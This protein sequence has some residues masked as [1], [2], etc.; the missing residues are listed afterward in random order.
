MDQIKNWLEEMRSAYLYQ[1][2]ADNEQ[3]LLQ[4]KMFKELQNAALKQAS[5]WEKSIKENHLTLPKFKPDLRIK[6][7]S[8]LVKIIGVR[9]LR[10]ILSAMKI[11]GMSALSASSH[12]EHQHLTTSSANNL[13][14]A[15]FG[16]NDGLVSNKLDFR[17]DRRTCE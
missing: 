5:I 13:R 3:D 16:I 1:V 9:N 6:I 10:Y 14:A 8:A 2:I 11:R 7:V 12:A 17:N 4:K 15:V